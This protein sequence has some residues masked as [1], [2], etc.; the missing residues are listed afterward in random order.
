MEIVMKAHLDKFINLMNENN[1]N[2]YLL[3]DKLRPLPDYNL[4]SVDNIQNYY[5]DPLADRAAKKERI[6]P[7]L[8]TDFK[9]NLQYCPHL[10]LMADKN[11][12]LNPKLLSLSL[13]EANTERY[14]DKRYI[15]AWLTSDLSPTELAEE[16]VATGERLAQEIP[17]INPRFLTYYEPFRMQLL[18]EANQIYPQWLPRQLKGI[19]QYCYFN[20][21]G[22]LK[23]IQKSE[24]D[25][26]LGFS[27]LSERAH[28]FQQYSKPIYLCFKTLKEKQRIT[29]P[30]DTL[31]M[32]V[33]DKWVEGINIGL[34]D[35]EDQFAFAMTSLFYH[36]DLMANKATE[37][38]V[39]NA[40]EQP[41]TL[42]ESLSVLRQLKWGEVN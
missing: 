34:S 10:I 17:T 41:G 5:F 9:H 15:C 11:E 13:Q 7:V 35:L 37:K 6:V 23:I 40:I 38:A 1:K 27:Q 31:L 16:L 28:S 32:V 24:Q 14:L 39:F 20:L 26:L 21:S 18:H 36:I 30:D 8:R 2:R 12:A 29:T 25:E 4:I 22:K 33:A 42:K 19:A 3:V